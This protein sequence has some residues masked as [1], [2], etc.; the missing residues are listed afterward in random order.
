MSVLAARL[1]GARAPRGADRHG[2]RPGPRRSP[3]P[4]ELSCYR[5][6]RKCPPRST[7]RQTV[8]S[9]GEALTST[10]DPHPVVPAS[11]RWANNL[12]KRVK[13]AAFGFTSFRTYRSVSCS[14]SA[15]PTGT[16]SP[17]SHPA[18][19]RGAAYSRSFG[20]PSKRASVA[21]IRVALTRCFVYCRE[22]ALDQSD[23]VAPG[24]ARVRR[25]ALVS[26]RQNILRIACRTWRGVPAEAPEPAFGA[27]G[28]QPTSPI[29]PG[30][31]EIAG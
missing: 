18:C 4:P 28:P 2:P 27:N 21:I 8:T 30:T 24:G 25:S 10:V 26:S 31:S 12:L 23:D 14:T 3:P 13:R 7:D 22:L 16:Y 15:G 17:R 29:E 5:S 20:M 6:P 11:T 19:I 9:I 1:A